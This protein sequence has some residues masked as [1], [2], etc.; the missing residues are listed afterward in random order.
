MPEDSLR[1]LYGARS[2]VVSER[3]AQAGD[4]SRWPARLEAGFGVSG[5][6]T[7]LRRIRTSGP[8]YIQRL[9]YPE[10]P[11]PSG[12][13]PAEACLLHPPGGLV[14][15]DDLEMELQLSEGAEALITTPAAAK[16]YRARDAEF[17]QRQTASAAIGPGSA[18]E[19]LPQETIVF[20]GARAEFITRFEAAPS[21]RL[22]CWDI[23][24][25][26]RP[27]AGERFAVGSFFQGLEIH[28]GGRPLLLERLSLS[29][30]EEGGLGL[31]ESP[32]GFAGSP[33]L[34][35][36][37]ALGREGSQEDSRALKDARDAARSLWRGQS[38]LGPAATLRGG[39]LCVRVLG[40]DTEG[41]RGALTQAWEIV[42]PRLLG[43]EA[44]R[45]RIWRT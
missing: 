42:R 14:S 2:S 17:P 43:R 7:V 22:I 44:E 27:E 31:L 10:G 3:V 13:V 41:I 34:G 24:S 45:P 16:A 35:L 39:A 25:L 21:A 19:W 15:G 18:L 28:R 36:L 37:V 5:G 20:S 29:D 8:L 4:F 12:V 11:G 26:G 23:I 33:C 32:A 6:R 40:P 38:A 9:F 30:G 1:S